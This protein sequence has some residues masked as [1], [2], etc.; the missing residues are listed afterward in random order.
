MP[1]S[2]LRLAVA[3]LAAASMFAPSARVAAQAQASDPPHAKFGPWG[4]DL[5]GADTTVRPGADFFRYVNGAWIARTEI[6]ADRS[7]YGLRATMS[8]LTEARLREILEAAAQRASHEPTTVEGKVGAFYRSF[9]DTARVERLG[10]TPIAPLLDAVR[11]ATT[12]SAIARLMGRGMSDFYGS[13][14]GVRIMVDRKDPSVNSVYIGQ[15]GLLLPDR[16]YYLKPEFASQRAALRQYAAAVLSLV[17]WPD[18]AGAAD[19]V[20]AF[21][22]RLAEVSW[23]RTQQRDRVATYN[24]MS[25]DSLTQL[26]PGFDWRAYLAGADLGAVRHVVVRE[27][28]AFPSLASVYA[29]TPVSTLQ[30]YLALTVLYHA[31]PYLARPFADPWFALHGRAITGQQTETVRWKRAIRAVGGGDYSGGD[32]FDRFGNLGWAVGKLYTDRYFPPTAKT[33]IEQLVANL[34]AA[35]RARLEGLD[36]MS[37]PTKVEALRK[38]DTYA[39]KVA[40]PDTPRDYS[41]VV[42]RDDDLIGNVRRTAAADW[43]YELRQLGRSVDRTQWMMTPQTNNAYNGALRDIVFPAGILQPPIFDPAAD[44]AVNYGAI[45]GVIGHELV[46]GFDDEGRKIDAAGALRDWWVPED[47]ARF[48]ERARMLGAQYSAYEPLPGLHVNGQLTMGE[49]IAD[50]GGLTVALDAYRASLHGAPSPVLDGMTGEQRVFLGWAQAW[51]TKRREAALRR[52]VTSDPHSPPESRVN[53]PVRNIDA[54]YTLFNVQP[55]DALYLAPEE[56][57]RI[58]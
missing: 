39:I 26:A 5:T 58:W 20:L 47:A 55:G 24:P 14:F 30:A 34:K 48:T 18:A 37:A 44:P 56:R 43:S 3:A 28:S 31:G 9:L 4:V 35:M 53:G 8:D 12:R 40:Y 29:A 6:P 32:R 51:R 36:W 21:E 49:N 2:L 17:G 42:I 16:D 10:A 52:Q 7:A 41:A 19:S 13:A 46:H 22:S 45:G 11:G 23:T 25:A 1:S 54:W 33:A 15:V 38:L 27:R 50:L 57:V